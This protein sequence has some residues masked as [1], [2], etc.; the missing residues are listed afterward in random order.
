MNGLR[1]ALC[2]RVMCLKGKGRMMKKAG[3]TLTELMVTISVVGLIAVL[4]VP[5]FTRFRQSWKLRGEADHLAGTMRA[6]RAAA[7]MKSIDAVFIFDMENRTFFYFE[8]AD[9]DGSR[10][11][12]EYRSAL[13]R[14]DPAIEFAA[15]TLPGTRLT[16][17]A[18]G[19]TPN[20]GSIT[21]RN[22]YSSTRRIRI[23][24]GSGNIT[25]E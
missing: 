21:L 3:F 10:D 5:G 8:D 13:Y 25:V 12:G 19:N 6:A 4:S 11:S 1:F 23:Y 17:G 2:V 18:K 9:R 15:H 16:F 22:S 7:V 24:G 20:S 14:L